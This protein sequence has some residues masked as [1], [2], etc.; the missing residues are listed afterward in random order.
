MKAPSP[1]HAVPTHVITGFLGVGKTSAILHLLRQKPD[2]EHWAVLVNEFG[3][4]GVDGSLLQGQHSE[5]QGIFIREV[6][7]GCMCCVAGVPMQVALNQL[8]TRAR[9][10]RLLIEPS[11]LGH[12]QEVLQALSAEHYQ[13]VLDLRS[14]LT[15]VD[16]RKLSDPRYTRHT[17]F[18]QQIAMADT[19]IGNKQ[20][21]Y[22]ADERAA[23]QA[24]V[25]QKGSPQAQV[26]F[27]QQGEIAP[28]YLEHTRSASTQTP[29]HA[30]Q[31][32]QQQPLLSEA[33]LP[34]SGYL[35]ALNQGEGFFSIGWR[36]ATRHVFQLQ[37]LS[38]WLQQLQVERLKAVFITTEGS[39][40]FNLTADG[41]TETLL[42]PAAESRIEMIAL[43]IQPEW[44]AQLLA[45]IQ[46]E[47]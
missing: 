10:H 12:P 11:G 30:H 38:A 14:V 17:T 40:G 21:L 39:R 44:E 26:V 41:F 18:N 24:Y 9:P 3:E 7:G 5:A 13:G 29:T 32:A 20:D 15:L 28:H 2:N 33:E 37:P 23:L 6:P 1:I 35:S 34:Q 45:C 47:D 25:A 19:I 42:A 4:I 8:L 22:Q 43:A 36:F 16:A 46:V 27:T 31:H